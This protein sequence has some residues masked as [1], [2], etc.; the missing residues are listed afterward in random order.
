MQTFEAVLY[1]HWHS[2]YNSSSSRRQRSPKCMPLSSR[3][4]VKDWQTLCSEHGST[5]VQGHDVHM[6]CSVPITILVC[7]RLWRRL[8]CRKVTMFRRNAMPLIFGV[9]MS[10]LGRFPR[11][12]RVQGTWLWRRM[13]RNNKMEQFS[14]LKLWQNPKFLALTKNCFLLFL[15]ILNFYLEFFRNFDF[16]GKLAGLLNI[17]IFFSILWPIAFY[18]ISLG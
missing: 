15:N 3:V 16:F 5:E 10:T 13:K 8:S 7:Y 11:L 17:G 12:Y 6:D 14:G 4:V 1:P 18:L 9:K 2:D